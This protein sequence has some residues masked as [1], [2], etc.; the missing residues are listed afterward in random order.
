LYI[1]I[2]AAAALA[3]QPGTLPTRAEAEAAG[4]RICVSPEMA[5][6]TMSSLTLAERQALI[7]CAQRVAAMM[8]S[9]RLPIQVSETTAV[10]A[11]SASGMDLTYEYRV[12]VDRPA[13]SGAAIDAGVTREVCADPGRVTAIAQGGAYHYLWR[14]RA[15]RLL[16]RLTV[17]RCGESPSPLPAT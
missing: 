11:V 7:A 17:N 14:N 13:F 10:V 1:W 3:A 5:R 15:G 12:S 2:A 16:H 8:L 4:A 9:E 6:R